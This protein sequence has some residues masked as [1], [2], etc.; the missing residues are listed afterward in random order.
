MTEDLNDLRDQLQDLEDELRS[1]E[2][3]I[4]LLDSLEDEDE[5]EKLE[6]ERDALKRKI[7]RLKHKLRRLKKEEWRDETHRRVRRKTKHF[8]KSPWFLGGLEHF[9][10]DLGETIGATVEGVVEGIEDVVDDIPCIPPMPHIRFAYPPEKRFYRRDYRRKKRIHIPPEDLEEFCDKTAHLFSDL[11]DKLGL[12]LLLELNKR[13]MTLDEL[14]EALDVDEQSLNTL[15]TKYDEA[16]FVVSEV[17][18]HRYLI[19]TAGF[20]ALRM[21]YRLFKHPKKDAF[22]VDVKVD[23]DE[24]RRG[25]KIKVEGETEELEED[26]GTEEE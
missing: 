3:E 22:E 1:I 20:M 18:K 8:R 9:F 24:R 16:G 23:V 6:D 7:R 5:L 25:L 21:A 17:V 2:R 13:P 12:K 4:A 10:E 14:K 19:T 11:S 15:L 26:K